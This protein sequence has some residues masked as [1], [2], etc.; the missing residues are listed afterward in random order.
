MWDFFK[1]GFPFH[2]FQV[3]SLFQFYPSL[4]DSEIELH[5][6]N[7]VSHLNGIIKISS[8]L[9]EYIALETILYKSLLI[10]KFLPR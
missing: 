1:P 5:Y 6:C 10:C 3:I 9:C 2:W 4:R 8:M 7:G